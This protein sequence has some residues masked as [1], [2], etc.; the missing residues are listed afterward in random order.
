MSQRDTILNHLRKHGHITPVICTQVYRIG[1][2]RKRIS[3]L[4]QDGYDIKRETAVDLEGKRYSRY[5]YSGIR[6][7]G[8][9]KA[10]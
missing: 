10:A 2:Y 4:K 9:K 1:D 3:E 7:V 5:V 6:Y 8:A